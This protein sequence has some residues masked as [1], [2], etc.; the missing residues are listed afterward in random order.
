M[1]IKI[2]R[3]IIENIFNDYFNLINKL[4]NDGS[5][6]ITGNYYFAKL[7]RIIES[8]DHFICELGGTKYYKLGD[9]ISVEILSYKEKID[10]TNLFFC[11]NMSNMDKKKATIEVSG[12][13]CS[14]TNISISTEKDIESIKKKVNLPIIAPA[15]IAYRDAEIPIK[16]AKNIDSF[17][18]NNV[19]LLRVDNDIE[20]NYRFIHFVV[21]IKKD[22]DD[23]EI[24]KI[25]KET[26]G[27][28]FKHIDKAGKII[29]IK[30]TLKPSEDFALELFN[31]SNQDV[32][33]NI[34]DKF[35]QYNIEDF[36]KALGYKSALSQKTLKWIEREEKD[37]DESI[38]DILL[39]KDD[40]YCD[41]LD[42]KKSLI[43][44]KSLTK[45]KKS[46]RSGEV[47]IR[48]CDYVSELVAQLKDYERYFSYG[49]NRDWAYKEYGI[50]VKNQK[51]IGIVG[52]YNNF[53]KSKIDKSL[54][55]DNLV[56][57]SYYDVA[58]MLRRL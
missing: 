7:I 6:T 44:L 13:G 17:S 51:L 18:L 56:L 38:P 11:Q 14:F 5:I 31:F 42:L 28:Q 8:P 32:K 35:I 54:D 36:A 57:Y 45:H 43:K 12:T 19:V 37:P 25:L 24:K 29:G 27:E 9:L 34:F 22:L 47:R 50:K 2:F 1:K 40:G 15:I 55:K 3:S 20:I 39:I 33:E 48:F 21:I 4:I 58:E 26:L 23:T 10:D 52:N 53:E 41:I 16:V 49:K 30:N 46:G